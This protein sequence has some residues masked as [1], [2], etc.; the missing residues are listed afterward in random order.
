MPWITGAILGGTALLGGVMGSNAASDAADAQ[1]GAAQAS[2]ETQRYMYDTTRKD[3][4]PALDVRN[5]SL[6]KM[7][8]LLGI[9]GDTSA[10][11][12][13]SLGGAINPGDVTQDPGYLFGMQ[14]GQAALNNQF[15]A[16]GMR[17]SGAALKAASRF[18]TDYGTTK[19]DQAFNRQVANRS[20]QLNPL[21]SLANTAQTGASTIASAGQNYANTVSGN[22]TALGNAF[23]SAG[24]AGTNALT[25]AANQIAGWYGSQSRTPSVSPSSSGG[26]GSYWTASNPFEY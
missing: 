6:D 12:F 11:G 24:I 14:Q 10:K 4:A 1:A 2:N 16:R 21:Q 5:A 20:A 22:Q 3:N 7:R 8:E 18:G 15:G 17:N 19:Y 26:Y 9:G 25:G 23:G 13:G